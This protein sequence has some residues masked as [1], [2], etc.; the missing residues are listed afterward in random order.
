MLLAMAHANNLTKKCIRFLTLWVCLLPAGNLIAQT[1]FN[2]RLDLSETGQGDRIRSIIS[3]TGGFLIIGYTYNAFTSKILLAKI[4]EIGQTE[5]VKTIGNSNSDEFPGFPGC[6]IRYN[7]SLIYSAGPTRFW[8]ND[9]SWVGGRV[10]CYNNMMDTLWTRLLI[11]K[12]IHDTSYYI[13]NFNK[14]IS[15]DFVYTGGEYTDPFP[16]HVLLHKSDKSGNIIWR[17]SY[18]YTG[19]DYYT[20]YSVIQTTDGGYAIGGHKYA[21][22]EFG[23]PL[24]IK[25]DSLGNQEWI[26]NF[27]GPYEDNKAMVCPAHDGTIICGTALATGMVSPDMAWARINISKITNDGNVLWNKL[28][29][30]DR[31]DNF[32]LNIRPTPDSGFIA[33]GQV[34]NEFPHYVGWL[35]KINRNGDSL[36]YREYDFLLGEYGMHQLDDVIATSDKGYFSSGYLTPLFLPDTGSVDTWLVKVDS[37][38][39][40]APGE[41]WVGIN[42]TAPPEPLTVAGGELSIRPNPA[43][44][45][46]TLALPQA[47]APNTGL[48]LTD[49]TGRRLRQWPLLGQTTTFDCSGLPPGVYF[50]SVKDGNG[51]TQTQKLLIQ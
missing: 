43:T 36:W 19:N 40:E 16:S 46:F 18:G 1:Y 28:Y 20:G 49:L 34:V 39:C 26:L 3:D 27:G 5:W 33:C 12:G 30:A 4:S 47:P 14:T 32:L 7:D 37:L 42:E 48:S 44:Q 2:K 38:G 25:T 31:M 29:G 51:H 41:C 24:V 17:K 21:P 13:Y 6:L 50:V 35:L 9:T 8:K 45:M 23:D 10:I 15:G 11:D 22:G